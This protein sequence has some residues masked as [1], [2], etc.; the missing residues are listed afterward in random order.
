[1]NGPTQISI[2][3]L[4]AVLK[5][6]SPLVW[7]RL[8]LSSATTPTDLHK[9]LQLAFDWSDFCSYE[10]R[11]HRKI[12]GS[13]GDDSRSVCLGDCQLPPA[14]RFRYR[15]ASQGFDLSAAWAAGILRPTRTTVAHGSIGPTRTIR[16]GERRSRA[17]TQWAE[18]QYPEYWPDEIASR[19]VSETATETRLRKYAAAAAA[20][21]PDTVEATLIP[22]SV[23]RPSE[24]R[25]DFLKKG[26][27]RGV[28]CL[29]AQAP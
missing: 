21:L 6:V 8:L 9:I 15:A 17:P 5:E 26:V 29:S 3:Q 11:I 1:M 20:A 4:R 18:D 7:R 14:E 23:M 28:I 19:D 16:S 2:D 13:N 24:T 12:L 22:E 27:D 10:F 25:V